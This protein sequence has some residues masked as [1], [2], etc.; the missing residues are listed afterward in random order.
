MKKIISIFFLFLLPASASPGIFSILNESIFDGS[1]QATYSEPT[2]VQKCSGH[3][4]GWIDIVGFEKLAVINGTEYV[5]TNPADAAI[6]KYDAWSTLNKSWNVNVD[7]LKKSVSSTY[8]DGNVTAS[9]HVTLKY[10]TSAL[11]CSGTGDSRHCWVHKTYYYEA[12]DISSIK[13]APLEMVDETNTTAKITIYNNTI[14]PKTLIHVPTSKNVYKT[15]FSYNNT[16]IIRWTMVGIVGN[17]NVSFVNTTFWDGAHI[18][19]SAVF[20][21]VVDVSNL[22]I[23]VSDPYHTSRISSVDIDE[24]T[25]DVGR[26]VNKLAHL[27]IAILV[28]FLS[29]V[30]LSIRRMI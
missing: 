30:Y 19:D 4:C 29:I 17:D 8:H 25:C 16:T 11:R 21:G 9:M 3:I 14:S 26:S 15:T 1:W 28:I 10:H 20:K 18:G 5:G 12:F 27:I 2:C 13:K 23:E 24:K 7:S 6:V 22:S